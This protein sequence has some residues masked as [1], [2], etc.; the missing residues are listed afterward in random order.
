[1]TSWLTGVY[2]CYRGLTVMFEIIKT[3]GQL[4]RSSWWK[5]LF[6]VVFRIFDNMKIPEA[7]SEV[8]TFPPSPPVHRS[9]KSIYCKF[10]MKPWHEM[11]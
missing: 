4:F 7:L 10:A 5:D 1:M 6:R 2:C 11:Y 3:Y 8:N 9:F